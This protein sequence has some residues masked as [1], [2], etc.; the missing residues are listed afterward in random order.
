MP[1]DALIPARRPAGPV[2][3]SAAGSAPGSGAGWVAKLPARGDF[4][5]GGR[6]GPLIESL[7][8][9]AEEGLAAVRAGGGPAR[10][11][12]LTAPLWR[13]GLTEGAVPGAP[14]VA[15]IGP[16]MDGAGRLFPILVALPGGAPSQAGDLP[17]RLLA[18]RAGWCDAVEDAALAA[19]APDADPAVFDAA[20]AAAPAAPASAPTAAPSAL[21]LAAEG[22]AKGS[23]ARAETFG[24]PPRVLDATTALDAAFFAAL[25]GGRTSSPDAAT[26]R[27]AP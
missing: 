21:G 15:V 14:G 18:A 11:A 6:P 9:W 24:P 26:Q 19:L 12:F 4:V 27:S 2:A 10:D 1:G 22:S 7:R 17:A 23:L 16:G 20:V 3:G 5:G 25:F 13:L 8:A